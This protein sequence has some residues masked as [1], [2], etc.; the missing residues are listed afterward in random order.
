MEVVWELTCLVFAIVPVICTSIDSKPYSNLKLNLRMRKD[1]SNNDSLGHQNEFY[2][3]DKYMDILAKLTKSYGDSNIP[4][5][6]M[7]RTLRSFDPNFDY[8]T[9]AKREKEQYE[10]L[11]NLQYYG[12]EIP[13]KFTA[14]RLSFAKYFP[15]VNA[16][17]SFENKPIPESD[18]SGQ[19]VGSLIKRSVGE[20]VIHQKVESQGT[21]EQSKMSNNPL[22][23]NVPKLDN[24][25]SKSINRILYLE[26]ARRL[27]CSKED[28]SRVSPMDSNGI[29]I[30]KRPSGLEPHVCNMDDVEIDVRFQELMETDAGHLTLV[31]TGT[32]VVNKCEGA[33]NTNVQPSVNSYDGF[34]RVITVYIKLYKT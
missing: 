17:D 18:N 11:Q 26:T 19:I 1:N 15:M 33:C 29:P 23:F 2:L 9:S 5:G 25:Q 8:L 21:N 32:I 20:P 24:E 3:R 13:K 4:L 6:S 14:K 16:D 22:P 12:S 31:C 27:N 10:N 30:S 34:E 28:D 7:Q